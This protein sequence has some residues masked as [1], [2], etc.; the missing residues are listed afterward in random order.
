MAH[1]VEPMDLDS[2]D[3]DF[4][5]KENSF[6]H[7]NV[8]QCTEKGYEELDVSELNM[9]LRY[10]ITPAGSPMSKSYT[11]CIDNRNI[12]TDDS[13]NY[14]SNEGNLTHSYNSML[15][16]NDN[17]N[18]I[19]CLPLQSLPKD[20]FLDCN[21]NASIVRQLDTVVTDNKT[22]TITS[23]DGENMSLPSSSSSTVQTPEATT[24]TKDVKDGGSPIM[25]GLKTVFNMF[26][27]STSPIPPLEGDGNSLQAQGVNPTNATVQLENDNNHSIAISTP[28]A[29]HKK[30]NSSRRNSPLKDSI[31]F[32][33]EIEKELQWKDE[34]TIFLNH[35]KIPIHKLF[36]QQNRPPLEKPKLQVNKVLNSTVEYMD[37]S[38]NDSQIDKTETE[39]LN[40][41]NDQG[42]SD[43]EFVDCES[44]FTKTSSPVKEIVE[45]D[46]VPLKNTLVANNNNSTME[47]LVKES[48]KVILNITVPQ[49]DDNAHIDNILEKSKKYISTDEIKTEMTK[50]SNESY[51]NNTAVT[52]LT[53]LRNQSN[54]ATEASLDSIEVNCEISENMDNVVNNKSLD[55]AKHPLA[56]NI[57][58]Q[59]EDVVSET[60]RDS[61]PD[62]L[63]TNYELDS[64]ESNVKNNIINVTNDSI[65]KD[66]K[67]SIFMAVSEPHS[68]LDKST[69]DSTFDTVL[70]IE[71][72]KMNPVV[73]VP[74]NIP[75]PDDEGFDKS[76]SLTANT[77][78][79]QH[80]TITN[81]VVDCEQIPS[82]CIKEVVSDTP[83]KFLFSENLN[84]NSIT[85]NFEADSTL[86]IGTAMN[87]NQSDLS[88]ILNDIDSILKSDSDGNL[89]KEKELELE[90]LM[91][92]EKQLDSESKNVTVDESVIKLETLPDI[93]NHTTSPLNLDN[94]DNVDMVKND[95][96]TDQ[97]GHI[98]SPIVIQS[99]NFKYEEDTEVL[100]GSSLNKCKNKSLDTHIDSTEIIENSKH[101]VT[102]TTTLNEKTVNSE[103]LQGVKGG[104]LGFEETTTLSSTVNAQPVEDR[105]ES[106]ESQD[107]NS[108]K[109]IKLFDTI[110]TPKIVKDEHINV[111][112]VK[113]GNESKVDANSKM[114]SDFI[115]SEIT[116]KEEL[117]Q[118]INNV[119]NFNCYLTQLEIKNDIKTSEI[120]ETK[121]SF[122]N[123]E[124]NSELIDKELYKSNSNIVE[125]VQH[126]LNVDL[127]QEIKLEVKIEEASCI[128]IESNCILKEAVNEE[129]THVIEKVL[130]NGVSDKKQNDDENVIVGSPEPA[131][132]NKLLVYESYPVVFRS[133]SGKE[134]HKHSENIDEEIMIS[135]NNSPYVS[136]A[137]DLDIVSEVIPK[138]NLEDLNVKITT[139]NN[140]SEST[141]GSPP[142]T[143]KGYNFNFDEFSDAFVTK[144]N[145]RQSPTPELSNKVFELPKN[146]FRES[147]GLKSEVFKGRRM[148]QPERK[149]PQPKKKLNTSFENINVSKDAL[150]NNFDGPII[151]GSRFDDSVLS[152]TDKKIDTGASEYSD[153]M[154]SLKSAANDILSTE[155]TLEEINI[156]INLNQQINNIQ[157]STESCTANKTSSSE[158]S[159]YYSAGTSSNESI[160]SKNV[161]NLPEIDDLN[162]NPFATKTKI[163]ASP[164]P[165]ISFNNSIEMRSKVS[166]SVP[167]ITPSS[168]DRSSPF[169]FTEPKTPVDKM[170]T[171]LMEKESIAN[172]ST[173][174][175]SSK[176]TDDKDVTVREIHTEDEDTD[177]GPFLE[178]DDTD[179]KVV[180]FDEGNIDMM[181]I[182][183]M[184]PQKQDDA[185]TKEL[186][187]D[188]DAFEFLLNQKSTNVV[189]DSGK[190][191]L[192]LK[193]DPLFAK[194]IS[195]DGVFAALSK[196]QRKQSTPSKL[197]RNKTDGTPEQ[198]SLLSTQL[199]N[200]T[201]DLEEKAMPE[202]STDD[203][204]ITVSKPMMVV[205]P[206][207]NPVPLPR[208]SITPTRT[209]RRSLT[210]TS[211][212]MAVIDRLLSMSANNSLCEESVSQISQEQLQADSALSQLREL[213]AEKEIH[214]YNLR[215]ESEE[216]RDRLSTM[217]MQMKSLEIEGHE[218][219]RNINDLNDKLAEKSKINKCMATVVEEYERTIASLIAETEQDKK[220]HAEERLKLT[221]ERDEQSAHLASMEVSFSD[222]HSKYEK[223][224]QV[225]LTYK[226]NEDAYKKSLKEFEENLTK[227]QNNYELLKQHATS[228]LNHA[229][230]EFEKMNRA[231]EAEVLKLNALI[232]RKD[233]HIT[234]L[235]ETL[236]QKTKANEELTAI[237]DE[238]INKVG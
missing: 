147:E 151:T 33:D 135:E 141:S 106:E 194:R 44:T 21:K 167:D 4:D 9:K 191:S 217:E 130:V 215:H 28:I 208:K 68:V 205:T 65:L 83:N 140:V 189:A 60:D 212:A 145:V 14:M 173:A 12:D 53:Q 238:L 232:K 116:K 64:L 81:D 155:K 162:F 188:A 181:N 196:I 187:I 107:K 126:D 131:V 136:V 133:D 128:N 234:S 94:L 87:F 157:K 144:T 148:S 36:L 172:S 1:N 197:N 159:T 77:A 222:L 216:L 226:A 221:N 19:K 47:Q 153:E 25:R 117:L 42:E 113:E 171:E 93:L 199:T 2:I 114:N 229:N 219:L 110:I 32:N 56:Q 30:E 5:N 31:V 195:S 61:N 76:S 123:V 184:K 85:D 210:F 175:C 108:E 170:D 213:L 146:S 190:E 132:D 38:Y 46:D 198:P 58:P 121:F 75:L 39:E 71:Q 72:P 180:N 158:H 79:A 225:I 26:R 203:Q 88:Q 41:K 97:T 54:N 23:H 82:V 119:D 43:G 78:N 89:L 49:N 91:K 185:E 200:M 50:I 13:L 164:P 163:R 57:I 8:L 24:P 73:E 179:I 138:N 201:R 95:N 161:F 103:E 183:N 34:T 101:K 202:V 186:F 35:E 125:P 177:E 166:P 63:V 6:H 112:D 111:V 70:D 62:S 11:H 176:A 150:N 16:K 228:K 122:V 160:K 120:N 174:T 59:I 168:T 29:A 67:S 235:E 17:I 52:N 218:R 237:C 100:N 15:S 3:S 92:I 193:F 105:K 118:N 22:I 211:P 220:K 127:K 207:V 142:I 134:L 102:E 192:F 214:V 165:H 45:Q 51:T 74:A 206:A 178:A 104:S 18:K 169:N 10:S 40:I 137:A 99:T 224:K 231:H 27:T 69:R 86:D 20:Q 152:V 109:G 230:Q 7:N 115:S 48:S 55:I 37:V 223:S 96:T 233:L 236:A 66:S 80:S 149:K 129:N 98:Y 84:F 204:N 90:S 156:E 139:K 143:S 182:H 124:A 209:N 227:M 154:Y